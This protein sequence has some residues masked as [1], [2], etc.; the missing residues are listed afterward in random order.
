M[1]TKNLNNQ[2]VIGTARAAADALNL[3]EAFSARR[4][5]AAELKAF[6]ALKPENDNWRGYATIPSGSILETVV[7]VFRA[8]TDIPLEVP[9]FTVLAIISAILLKRRVRIDALGSTVSPA[10]M[11]VLLAPSGSGKSFTWQNTVGPVANEVVLFPEPASSAAFV[12]LLHRY[13]NG[14][15]IRDEFGQFIR[16]LQDQK[17]M[18]EMK[19]YLLRVYDG[20]TIERT[21]KKDGAIT[22]HDP[23]LA[24]LGFTVHETFRSLVPAESL[25]DGFAQRFQFV[26][27]EPDPERPMEKFPIY[28]F[29]KARGAIADAWK[30]VLE[31][32]IHDVY[33][34]GEGAVEAYKEAFRAIREDHR[35]IAGSFFRRSMFNAIRYGLLYHVVLGKTSSVLDADDLAWA[36]KLVMLHISDAR[37]LLDEFG[38]GELER[39][40]RKVE[41]IVADCAARG[42]RVT[43]RTIIRRVSAVRTAQQAATLLAISRD[44]A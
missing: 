36:A 15:W 43:P 34:L 5:G 6:L 19:D 8:K 25:V 3:A 24:I 1:Q 27:A 11:T 18:A 21:T 39:L 42:E 10:T 32:P 29:S 35:E 2:T 13:T 33:K 23:A 44:G 41:A 22:V 30:R 26:I 14:I 20:T 12:E 40:I 37:R 4:D 9:L 7:D 38:L 28:D 17:H 31:T 16:A